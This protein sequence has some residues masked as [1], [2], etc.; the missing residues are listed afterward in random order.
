MIHV[1]CTQQARCEH[2]RG[3]SPCKYW[4]ELFNYISNQF[5]PNGCWAD[6]CIFSLEQ[7]FNRDNQT[8]FCQVLISSHRGATES[9]LTGSIT[10]RIGSRTGPGQER[11]KAGDS[12]PP[13]T[14]WV[15]IHRVSETSV[16]SNQRI[17]KENTKL[18]GK[19][20]RSVH[21]LTTGLADS[22]FSPQVVRLRR[23]HIFSCAA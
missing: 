9:I 10:N 17:L 19:R 2:I 7:H 6:V 8:Q 14:L 12:K 23:N 3:T 4:T 20:Y 16:I 21:R 15:S 18:S 13:R 1:N 11:S 5:N 22:S